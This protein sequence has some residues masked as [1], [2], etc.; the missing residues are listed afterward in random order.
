MMTLQQFDDLKSQYEVVKERYKIEVQENIFTSRGLIEKYKPQIRQFNITNS[1]DFNVFKILG[2]H[3][4]EVITHT[5]FISNLLTPNENH[6][7]SNLFL[8]KFLERLQVFSDNEILHK[9]WYVKKEYEHIDLRIVNNTLKKA[10]FIENKIDTDAHSEQLSR[11]FHDWKINFGNGAFIYLTINGDSPADTGF[12]ELYPKKEVMK[13][14]KLLS[15]KTD[16]Y[17]WLKECYDEIKSDKVRYTI[18]QYM[19]LI[20]QL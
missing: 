5:P 9:D 18:L 6:F 11:Y 2:L 7:Q 3:R 1:P 14:L 19:E 8:R 15:Y 16:I 10:I 12:N 17:S 20:K 13:E 4:K